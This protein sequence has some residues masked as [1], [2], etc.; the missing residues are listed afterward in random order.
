MRRLRSPEIIEKLQQRA[1]W[2]EALDA[3]ANRAYRSFLEEISQ[4]HYGLLRDAV[5]KL[6][7]ADCLLSL[8]ILASQQDFVRP[9]FSDDDVLEIVAGRHPM[10]E[11][12]RDSPFVPNTV[13]LDPR[14]QVI[15]GPNMGGKSSVVRMIALCIIVS[16]HRLNTADPRLWTSLLQMAQIGSYV[17]AESMK[18]AMVD[19]I[20]VRMGGR[21]TK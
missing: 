18:L 3:E 7:S 1:Q 16:S 13:Q 14:H 12:L 5:N 10:V 9:Q 11:A 6:A 2:K 19:G 21:S 4:H 20:L 8:A 17:P 15:T